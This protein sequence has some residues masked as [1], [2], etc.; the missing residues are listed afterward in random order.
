[1]GA[2]AKLER[3]EAIVDASGIAPRIEALLPVGVRPRQLR[4]RTL[5]V[6]MLLVAVDG[7]P[8]HLSRVHGA[9]TSLPE[10]EQ[11]RLGVIVEWKSGP[12]RLT[13]RQV[14][15][16]F[17]LVARALAK[18][19]PDG[20]PSEEL[21]EILEALLEAN[22]ELCGEPETSSYAVDWTDLET[23][24]CPPPKGGGSCGDPEAAW[25]HRRGDSPGEADE[26][27][28]G[29]YLQVVTAVSEERGPAV[30]ELVRRIQIASC[31]ADP[32]VAL[33]PVL[34]RMAADGIELGDV[35]ADSGYAHRVA[36]RWA[37][38]VR[39]LG[40]RLVQD[41]HPHD[42]GPK[43]TH[44]GAT[45]AGGALYCPATPGALLELGPLHRGATEAETAA[46]DRKA[47]ELAAHKL[48][49]LT[50]YDE[51]GYRRVGCPA[52]RGKLRCPLRPASMA[53]EHTRPEVASPPEHPPV[54]C[55]QRTIT[56]PPEVNAKTAQKHD[57]PSPEHRRSYARRAAAE[58]AYA[59]VKDPASNDLS[60]G[61]CRLMGLAPIALLAAS[62]FVARNLRVAE[63]FAARA[64]E[65]ERRAAEG[66]PPK[67]RRRRRKTAGDLI[68]AA[69]APP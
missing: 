35:L 63:A 61:W 1:V 39:R 25:G 55:A 19:E 14:E 34:G 3:L 11:L 17:G 59:T 31:K 24:S 5:L 44:L 38:P 10:A 54:C 22:V 8:A 50:G 30:P 12:H 18:A 48:G 26:V 47:A 6:G 67:R 58:R 56:V 53:L 36:E 32:P 21:C 41:L 69:S 7:R 64:A 15:R 23:F 27:F 46:H 29:Y 68:G 9:L 65:D 4:V 52:A 66:L 37:L 42:R 20:E 13:Y 62:V 43:G 16:T 2:E 57:Y 51:D 33:V 49:P 45:L 28:Y 60:R 40:A